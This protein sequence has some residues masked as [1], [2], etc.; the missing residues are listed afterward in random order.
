M[1]LLPGLFGR[2]LLS[3]LWLMLTVFHEVRFL[4]GGLVLGRGTARL[5]VVRLGGLMVRKVRGNAV[6]P[7]DG[8]DVHMHS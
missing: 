3:L 4:V 7:V 1:F 6:D 8:R 2:L 5:R